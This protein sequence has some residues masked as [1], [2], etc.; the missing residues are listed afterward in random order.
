MSQ[1]RAYTLLNE[2]FGPAHTGAL[3]LMAVEVQR[4]RAEEL[5]YWL[6]VYD[7]LR[8]PA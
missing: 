4:G 6:T 8:R 1:I 3:L 5:R 7:G 2:L